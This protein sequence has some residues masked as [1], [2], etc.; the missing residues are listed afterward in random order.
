ME[1]HRAIGCF[2]DMCSLRWR[3][4][5]HV[6]VRVCVFNNYECFLFLPPFVLYLAASLFLLVCLS[7]FILPIRFSVSSVNVCQLCWLF[8]LG[9]VLAPTPPAPGLGQSSLECYKSVP[10]MQVIILIT[11]T[12]FVMRLKCT[13]PKSSGYSVALG[14]K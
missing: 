8:G 4:L 12:L 9:L 13:S 10:C 2:L 7:W 1:S 6:R 5:S 11:E 3:C 14:A